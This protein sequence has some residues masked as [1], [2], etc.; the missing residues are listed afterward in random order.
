VTV[1]L[2]RVAYDRG[3]VAV[4]C[5]EA[6]RERRVALVVGHGY[7]SSKQ[8]LDAM[9]AFLASH[10]FAIYSLDFPGHKLGASGGVLR[11]EHDLT[12]AMAAVVAAARADGHTVV[13]TVGH[14]MGA[15][16]ALVTAARD[17]T[18]AG[19]VSIAT[20]LGRLESIE[21]LTLGGR[22]DLRSSYVDGM[23]LPEL[24]AAMDAPLRAALPLLGGRPVLV[25][26]A[27]RDMMVTQANVRALFDA[28]PEPKTYAVVASDHTYAGENARSALLQW[29]GDRHPRPEPIAAETAL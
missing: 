12:G 26:A 2:R 4:L 28:I 9:C 21:R 6:R 22:V 11:D 7:S 29:L 24:V 27:E 25:V 17:A 13:Y 3:E 16:T 1:A 5:Y 15:M 19:A 20:G 8:N 23:S 14:S 10:G 18:I